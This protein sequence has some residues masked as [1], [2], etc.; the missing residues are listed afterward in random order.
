M[1]YP[2]W[3]QDWALQDT[4]TVQLPG[5]QM[6]NECGDHDTGAFIPKYFPNDVCMLSDMHMPSTRSSYADV[7]DITTRQ[8]LCGLQTDVA[9]W[10]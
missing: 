2:V 10:L 9:G 1:G 7:F 8:C 3:V 4:F 6:W 5:F